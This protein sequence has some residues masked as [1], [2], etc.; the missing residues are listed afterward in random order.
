MKSY[1]TMR[2]EQ[3]SFLKAFE[4][5]AQV[6]VKAEMKSIPKEKRKKLSP[7]ELKNSFRE[8]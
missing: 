6:E 7:Q 4:E 2:S 1:L 5:Q 8:V 3:K